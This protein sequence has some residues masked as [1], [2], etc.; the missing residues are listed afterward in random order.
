MYS[1]VKIRSTRS[2]R[3]NQ[4]LLTAALFRPTFHEK[5]DE[6]S[7]T[8][9]K[10]TLFTFHEMWMTFPVPFKREA[11]ERVSVSLFV[12]LGVKISPRST[13]LIQSLLTAALFRPTFHEKWD[14]SFRNK[15]HTPTHIHFSWNVNVKTA[16]FIP[17]F[18]YHRISQKGRFAPTP[19][20]PNPFQCFSG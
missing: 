4:N 2:T 12:R 16:A 15:S 3:S 1:V 6:P 13:R 8:P 18:F 19:N 7:P 9:I 17:Y 14:E 11:S 10:H 5:W 20:T